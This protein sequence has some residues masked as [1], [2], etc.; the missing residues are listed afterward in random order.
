MHVFD[1]SGGA[2][3]GSGITIDVPRTWLLVRELVDRARGAGA[4]DV[5]VP[6]D[7]GEA[8]RARDGVGEPEALIAARAQ[9]AQAARRQRARTT[10]TCTSASTARTADRAYGCVDIGPMELLAEREAELARDSARRIRRRCARPRDRR[11]RVGARAAGDRRRSCRRHATPHTSSRSAGCYG[12]RSAPGSIF[13]AGADRAQRHA[14]VEHARASSGSVR[15]GAPQAGVDAPCRDRHRRGRRRPRLPSAA[16][17]RSAGAACAAPARRP[18]VGRARLVGRRGEH[19]ADR[20]IRAERDGLAEEAACRPRTR[21]TPTAARR[22]RSP[23][24]RAASGRRACRC[25]LQLR[26]QRARVLRRQRVGA[27]AARDR[28]RAVELAREGL[29]GQHDLALAAGSASSTA[30]A[31]VARLIGRAP[32]A[33]DDDAE[34]IAR[35]T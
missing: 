1:A 10:I 21:T 30:Q 20:A 26:A 22:P 15:R 31:R 6:A 29:G 34:P 8:D 23:W 3:D 25:A 7:R 28:P 18:D 14:G 19:E 33:R 16:R 9:R 5:H 11:Q 13:G 12:A 27:R 17:R 4:V 35:A 2:R 32:A 24:G